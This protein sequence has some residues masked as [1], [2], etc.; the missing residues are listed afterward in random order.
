M[1]LAISREL[2]SP[3][4]NLTVPRIN[5]TAEIEER[6]QL[7]KGVRGHGLFKQVRVS[8]VELQPAIL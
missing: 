6:R 5:L 1:S 8:L 2:R 7:L 4:L 3:V